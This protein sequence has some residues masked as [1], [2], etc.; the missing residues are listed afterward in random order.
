LPDNPPTP[1]LPD[2]PPPVVPPV[3]EVEEEVKPPEGPKPIVKL[4]ISQAAPCEPELPKPPVNQFMVEKIGGL[5]VAPDIVR[6][7]AEVVTKWSDLYGKRQIT[8]VQVETLEG[9][10]V[11]CKF[12]PMREADRNLKGIIQIPEKI[13]QI[14]GTGEGKLVMVKPFIFKMEAEQS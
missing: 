13:L 10:A 4:P 14:L 5:M 8:H 6:V 12:R 9:R 1:E 2:N 7:D 11:R 3:K